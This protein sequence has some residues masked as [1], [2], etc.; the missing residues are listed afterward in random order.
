MANNR[1]QIFCKKCLSVEPFMKYYP[2]GWFSTG[3][4]LDDWLDIHNQCHEQDM[5]GESHY[6]FRT[7]IDED[8]YIS[9]YSD[10]QN[11]RLRL[12]PAPPDVGMSDKR[13]NCGCGCHPIRNGKPVTYV[14]CATCSG[15]GNQTI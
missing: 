10:Y 9:D 3:S 13:D 8:Q 14:H 11:L 15:T 5:G 12:K 1:A 4:N 6:G 2:G 7:E